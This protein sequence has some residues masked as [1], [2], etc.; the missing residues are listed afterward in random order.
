MVSFSIYLAAY[1][2]S[3]FIIFKKLLLQVFCL[4]NI[5]ILLL[6]QGEICLWLQRMCFSLDLLHT[7]FYLYK[8]CQ[9]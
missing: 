2:A 3:Q 8:N 4:T 6:Y 9:G 5:F 7:L 1:F